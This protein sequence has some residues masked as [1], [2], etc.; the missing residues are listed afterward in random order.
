MK[1]LPFRIP[2]IVF[3]VFFIA[4]LSTACKG[5]ETTVIRQVPT[6]ATTDTVAQRD[7][8]ATGPSAI[9][10]QLNI[11]ELNRIP[12]LDPLFAQNASTMRTL[13]LVYEGLVRYDAKGSVVPGIAKEW[14]VSPDSLTYQFTLRNNTYYHDSDAFSNGIGRKLVAGDVKYAFERMAKIHVPEN[15]AQLFMDIKGFQ[16]YYR[17]QHHVFNPEQRILS[18]VTGI[19]TPD[20]STVVF[21]LA[22]KDSHFLQKL[23]SPYAVIYPREA[24][25]DNTPSQFKAVGAGPFTLSQRRGDSLYVFA[26]FKEYY[27]S[28]QPAINRVDVKVMSNESDLFK[29]FARGEI[30]LI[31]EL[32]PGIMGS[33]LNSQGTLQPGYASDYSLSRPG[34]KTYYTLNFNRDAEL[35][36]E[37]ALATG[38]VIDSTFRFSDLPGGIISFMNVSNHNSSVEFVRGDTVNITYSDD[39]FI[40]RFISK[41]NS[42]LQRRGTNLQMNAIRT[43][44]RNIGLYMHSNIPFYSGQSW[45]YGLDHYTLAGFS[46]T[47]LALYRNDINN[48]SFNI[49]PWWLDL[50][51]V[52]LPALDNL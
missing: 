27:N 28:G 30:H 1:H 8:T 9:F 37:K 47:H 42:D 49:Y 32:G 23:S 18:G 21:T 3:A 25:T 17:E 52:T 13:Q 41:L 7:T 24:V 11:G 12:T 4:L 50:R 16:P 46:T 34:G 22:K 38:A 33:V 5:P 20:D 43:P 29:A 19:T 36:E 10:R 48:L 2:G 6:T 31:P 44:T 15:A 26:K 40:N 45:P 14:T 51:T 35:S 39:I